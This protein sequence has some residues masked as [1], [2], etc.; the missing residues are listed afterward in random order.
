MSIIANGQKIVVMSVVF[1]LLF[2]S[3]KLES[4]ES[5]SSVIK[6]LNI[7]VILDTSNRISEKKH[8]GQIERDKKIV[9]EIITQFNKAVNEH[10]ENDSD[11]KYDSRLEIVIPSQPSVPIIPW[12]ITEKLIIEDVKEH[13]SMK[14]IRSDLEN[15]GKM[16]LEAMPKLYEFVKKNKQTGC[17]IWEW[18]R[19]E[20]DGFFSKKHQNLIICISDGYLDFDKNIENMRVER[21]YMEVEELRKDP[22]WNNR[23]QGNKGLL[24]IDKDFSSYNVKFLM[25]EI[26]VR[27][28]KSGVPYQIDFEIIREYWKTWLKSMKIENSDF[29]KT[30]SHPARKIESY[31]TG[32]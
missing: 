9:E 12:E 17:D 20:A 28:D 13:R 27:S 26:A 1:F 31:L 5:E 7:I 23:I 32:E 19:S 29:I 18:F 14:G 22:D 30:G 4:K 10:I 15:Q 25:L 2:F 11:L 21:T 3:S 8:P 6:P 16:V 24:P